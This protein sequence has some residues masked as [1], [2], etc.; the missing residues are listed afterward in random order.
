MSMVLGAGRRYVAP[1]CFHLSYTN[2]RWQ[3]FM[4]A[5]SLLHIITD[6]VT[7]LEERIPTLLELA[8]HHGWHGDLLQGSV[9]TIKVD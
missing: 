6:L 1:P 2:S 3:E 5:K 7:L 8:P 4:L 9:G